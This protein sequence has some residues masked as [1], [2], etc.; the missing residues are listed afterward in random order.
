MKCPACEKDIGYDI[1]SCPHCGVDVQLYRAYI[2]I[3][4]FQNGTRENLEVLTRRQSQLEDKLNAFESLLARRVKSGQFTAEKTRAGN[5]QD[6]D[7]PTEQVETAQTHRSGDSPEQETPSTAHEYRPV[8][9]P[10]PLPPT[11]TAKKPKTPE[12]E[13]HFGQKWLLIIGVA[14]TVLGIAYFLKYAFDRE[15]IGPAGRVAMAYLAGLGFLAT[16]EI[17]RRKGEDRF[18]LY[19]LGGGVAVLYLSTYASY[20]LYG[21]FDQPVAFGLMILTTALSCSLSL[22]YNTMW[23]T[24]LGL[25]GGFATPVILSTG[26]GNFVG[27]MSYLT[28]LNAGVLA[29]AFFKQW[30]LLNFFGFASTWLIY[31]AFVFEYQLTDLFWPAMIF[32]NLFFLIYNFVPFAYFLFKERQERLTSFFIIAPNAFISFGFNFTYVKDYYSLEAV[33]VISLLYTAVF[34]GM[35]N[36]IYRRAQLNKQA[37]VLLLAKA[38]LFLVITV[39]I[40]FSGHWIT[41]FWALQATV[42]GWASVRLNNRKLLISSLLLLA[43]AMVKFLTYDYIAVFAVTGSQEHFADGYTYLLAGRYIN[44]F[45]TLGCVYIFTKLLASSPSSLLKRK[46]QFAGIVFAAFILMLFRVLNLETSAFF[47]DFA[48]RARFAAISVVWTLFSIGLMVLGFYK[49]NPLIRKASIGLF[50]LTILKVFFLDMKNVSTPYRILSFVVLGL[51]L[52][53]ASYLYY[54]FKDRL[55]IPPGQQKENQ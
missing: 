20:Q 4:L 54:K 5:E 41:I 31:T 40:L 47:Y 38:V 55:L 28:L 50:S 6:N 12:A 35:A 1:E 13:I 9:S 33:T 27:L 22:L 10:P 44:A 8:S 52:I 14:I 15:W 2:Q 25:M 24:L 21:L 45:I 39:P 7:N 19:L 32:T 16:G 37:V 17:F 42:L 3:K 11:R 46:S 48:P 34:A 30:R 43:G 29:I 51:V 53:G 49:N 36:F 18:G 26:T 23:L